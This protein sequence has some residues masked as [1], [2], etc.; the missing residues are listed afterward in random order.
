[1]DAAREGSAMTKRERQD[2]LH[3]KT[4]AKIDK[5]LADVPIDDRKERDELHHRLR[6]RYAELEPLKSRMGNK[7]RECLEDIGDIIEQLIESEARSRR[8]RA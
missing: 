2:D 7:E 4:R 5:L 1:M 6:Q 3:K 8:K